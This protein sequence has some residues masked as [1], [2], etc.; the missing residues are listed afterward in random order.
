M[1]RSFCFHSGN[2]REHAMPDPFYNLFQNK[3]QV[4]SIDN[5]N[6]GETIV[7]H[8]DVANDSSV[9]TTPRATLYQMRIFL[10]GERHTG[11]QQ[12]ITEHIVGKKIDKHSRASE[13]LAIP[14]PNDI[15]LSIKTDLI[16]V[17]Y[18]LHVTL[19][20]PHAIDLHVNLPIL[21]TTKSA[22]DIQE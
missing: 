20:I 18:F 21:I 1:I 17:K 11:S 19:D 13:I 16:S 6:L 10:F 4:I 5:V 22:L 14:V 3:Q 2:T 7:L 12:A 15:P 8:C 9:E